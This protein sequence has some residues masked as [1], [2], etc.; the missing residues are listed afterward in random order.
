MLRAL[1]IRLLIALPAL[2]TSAAA[3]TS[4]LVVDDDGGAG[5]DFTD[6]QSAIDA[7]PEG[8]VVLVRDGAYPSFVLAGQGVI[9]A[10]DI[11]A[12]PLFAGPPG[13]FGLQAGQSALMRG[14][15]FGS[16]QGALAN[17]SIDG[18]QGW[19]GFE[20]CRFDA[21]TGAQHTLRAWSSAAVVLSRC[22]LDGPLPAGDGGAALVV[23]D[24]DVHLF[25]VDI[26]GG[27]GFPGADGGDAVRV[28]HQDT[29]Q[30]FVLL[31][32]CSLTGG[33]GAAGSAA[34]C[35][36]GE[37]GGN[38]LTLVG[39]LPVVE[40]FDSTLVPGAG[41]AD[42]GCGAGAPGLAV[43]LLG[44]GVVNTL[45]GQ[46]VDFVVDSP[47]LSGTVAQNHFTGPPSALAFLLIAAAPDAQFLS[48]FSGTLSCAAPF[49]TFFA[50]VVPPSGTHLLPVPV[51][52]PGAIQAWQFYEQAAFLVPSGAI[53][54]ATP[55]FPLV[56]Q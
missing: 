53:V 4:A 7:S 16:L 14:L 48:A 17:G 8:G 43:E 19:V 27:V 29:G 39:F 22:E 37:D 6:V 1:P 54:L 41:G 38:A 51:T 24:S 35:T 28:E 21:P 20:D 23:I 45:P 30:P 36:S 2:A 52:L 55:T 33:E 42:A 32:G 46:A 31:S 56:V 50:G 13:V 26:E 12:S 44:S 11:G 5:V 40:R 9:V 18:C 25:D 10:A 15:H 47:V 34:P 49:F 3:Q